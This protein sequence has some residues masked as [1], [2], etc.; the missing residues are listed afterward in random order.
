MQ[1]PASYDVVNPLW[2]RGREYGIAEER[3]SILDSLRIELE[4]FA[5]IY[6]RDEDDFSRG[7]RV[8]LER[9]IQEI[10]AR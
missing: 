3:E 9:V 4:A 10:A 1:E 2:L 5:K 7:V 6:E 8:A